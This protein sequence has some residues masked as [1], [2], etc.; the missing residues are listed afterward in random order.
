MQRIL[1][2]LIGIVSADF[3]V[4]IFDYIL[5]P[6]M[7]WKFGIVWGGVIMSILS[8]LGCWLLMIFYN[9]SKKDWLGI[10]LAKKLREYSGNRRLLKFGSWILNRGKMISFLF[11]SVKFDPFVTTAYMQKGENGFNK[12][13]FESWKIFVASWMIG[14]FMWIIVVFTGI[15]AGEFIWKL[16]N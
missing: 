8:F 11:L 7:I 4:R 12:M 2:L 5:Y 10:E 16:I 14:N 3:F 9:F 6:Y 13:D 1:I 15:S